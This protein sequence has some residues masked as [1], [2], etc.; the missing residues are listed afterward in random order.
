MNHNSIDL[1]NYGRKITKPTG[2]YDSTLDK[3]NKVFIPPRISI[4]SN[5]IILLSIIFSIIIFTSQYCLNNLGIP[6]TNNNICQTNFYKYYYIIIPLFSII[7]IYYFGLF[8][9]FIDYLNQEYFDYKNNYPNIY[10]TLLKHN[11]LRFFTCSFTNSFFDFNS[12]SNLLNKKKQY[13]II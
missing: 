13:E 4:N 5:I 1:S 7:F 2:Y 12:I 8:D 9:M 11:S 10:S 3:K 6:N